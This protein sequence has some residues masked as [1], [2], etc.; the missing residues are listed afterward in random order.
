MSKQTLFAVGAGVLSAASALAFL[1]RAP[2][3]LIIV[4]LA[5][6]PLF[7]AGLAIGPRAIGIAA[8]AGF[9]TAGL[10]GGA[11]VAGIYG[12]MQTLPAWLLVKQSLLRRPTGRGGQTEWYPVGDIVCWLAL[13]AAALLLV[14][15][16]TTSGERGFQAI[17]ADNLDH[18]LAAMAPHL[19]DGQRTR[20]V[21][22]MAPL[23]P[24]AVGA[25]WLLMSVVNAALA[26]TILVRMQRNLRPS[27][28][29]A[30]TTL[31]QW[32]S[33]PLVAA[34]AMS[35]VGSGDFQYLGRNLA[36][37]LAV[38]FF[39]VGLGV[40]HTLARRLAYKGLILISLYLVLVLSGWAMV[41]VAAL[42]VVEQ[43]FGV[44]D[45]LAGPPAGGPPAMPE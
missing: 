41:A 19:G 15:A 23:F 9:I 33:W 36:M 38:P 13:L 2:G 4:Y 8:V 20:A 17:I 18:L 37:V 42:G 25:S 28:A 16:L 22:A 29:Y 7:M 43:W 32:M 10:F 6:L 31:P 27:P 30:E 39:F 5:S 35:L 24:G 1:T 11:V 12:L 3:S 44:R 26:Q 40:I 21:G 34:A 14:V 45:R